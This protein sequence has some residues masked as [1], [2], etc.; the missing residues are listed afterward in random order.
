MAMMQTTARSLTWAANAAATTQGQ[1]PLDD[2]TGKAGGEEALELIAGKA[3]ADGDRP[4]PV[5]EL[6][7]HHDPTPVRCLSSRKR[8]RW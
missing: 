8:R 6:A 5:R 1:A 3:H 7:A 2:I 4:I